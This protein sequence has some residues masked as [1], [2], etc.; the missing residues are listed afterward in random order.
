MAVLSPLRMQPLR[1]QP[2]QATLPP[3]PTGSMMLR[4]IQMLLKL[5]ESESHQPK[6]AWATSGPALKVLNAE[7][8]P[9]H[10]AY[11]NLATLEYST[12]RA[13]R[14]GWPLKCQNVPYMP[15]VT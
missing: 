15:T 6:A 1:M 11:L 9:F 2:P 3:P 12:R 14:Q 13:Q 4:L 8:R 5:E 7:W 10:T